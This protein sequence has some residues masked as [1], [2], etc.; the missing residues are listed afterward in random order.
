[1]KGDEGRIRLLL[2]TLQ[3]A[4]GV[5][6]GRVVAACR[7]RA[8]F[9]SHC[10]AI[11]VFL[12]ND[13]DN[14]C[15]FDII[16]GKRR[17]GMGKIGDTDMKV[18][19]S[20]GEIVPRDFAAAVKDIKLAILQS[21]ARAAHAS[22]VE[23]LKLYFYV[24]GYVSKKTRTAKWGSGAIDALSNRLQVELPGLRGFS[25][26]SIKYM[27]ILFDEWI[28]HLS[29][30]QSSIDES[31][32]LPSDE[33]PARPIRQMPSDESVSPD[34]R[35]TSLGESVIRSLSTNELATCKW[36]NVF[37]LPRSG[38]RR[39][40]PRIRQRSQ[41]TQQEERS[42][43]KKIG[44]TKSGIKSVAPGYEDWIRSIKERVQRARFK[45]LMMA[46]AEQIL[47][48]L[49]YMRAFVDAW[50]RRAI[51]QAP[52]GQLPWY[53]HLTWKFQPKDIGQLGF[54]M[55]AIDRQVKSP[56][57][58]KTIGIV[59]C[60]SRNDIVAEYA[61]ADLDKPIGVSTYQLG[62]PPLEQ[63]QKKLQQ[64]LSLPKKKGRS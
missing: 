53:H 19:R 38:H 37:H 24:G 22:N 10:I 40:P 59:L 21:R 26:T 2:R 47:R 3:T 48:A 8:L 31:R 41:G 25:A 1:M 61:L 64:V 62:L 46:N 43:M 58:G 42:L 27:R 14:V 35:P 5:A 45:A 18:A 33:S 9:P 20:R 28:P 50:G 16:S 56:I 15:E 57:D 34:N 63:L 11:T 32:H 44:N 17:S 52:L 36:R 7:C 49:M 4:S 60:R 13:G 12:T 23:A 39:C 54:Y 55:T 6:I 30:R 29:I 51:V